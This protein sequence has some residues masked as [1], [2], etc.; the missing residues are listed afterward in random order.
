M[1]AL[2]WPDGKIP[3]K[4]WVGL[5]PTELW[6]QSDGFPGALLECCYADLKL[7]TKACHGRKRREKRMMVSYKV[8]MREYK[9]LKLK[10]KRAIQYI[11]GTY[12]PAV[13]LEHL[14]EADPK[15]LST[16]HQ[17]MTKYCPFCPRNWKSFL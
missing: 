16:L 6:L 15:F 4:A 14:V 11:L 7:L 2:K 5:S 12:R 1:L 13:S 10:L 9:R 17:R 3:L 8:R